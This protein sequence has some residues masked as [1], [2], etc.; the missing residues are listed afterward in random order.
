D[1]GPGELERI[2][3]VIDL[4]RHRGELLAAAAGGADELYD[5]DG[6]IFER[7]GAVERT[8]GEAAHHD[9]RL[10]AEAGK[11]AEAAA[12]VEDVARRLS[13]YGG[14]A[15][16]DPD[17]L[18]ELDD[19]REALRRLTRKHRADLDGVIA[20][21]AAL[22]AERE[23][24][25]RFEE[26]IATAAA[27]LDTRRR[28]A[29]T[30][31]QDLRRARVETASKLA[32]AVTRELHD[33]SFSGAG[34]EVRI[35]QTGGEPGAAGGDRVEFHAA[36]NPGEGCHPLRKAA[37][38][39]ELSR[40]MLAIRRVLAGVG[41]VGS[42]VFD[43]VDAGI[44]GAVAA[45]VGLKLREVAAHH[46]VICVTHLPQ[47]SALADAHFVVTKAARRG[48]TVT[49]VARLDPEQRV[50]EVAR[51]LGGSRVTPAIRDAARELLATPAR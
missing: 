16:A 10:A 20:L 43:E 12:L 7:L 47:I 17:R 6:S 22:A 31:A 41:P 38:G 29:A 28:E 8:L 45:A 24:L 48:R 26:A 42:Y 33:L 39:G 34:F 9:P 27:D 44:G 25:A 11:L 49:R 14:G 19:R 23:T 2:E 15:E 32:R 46:Q 5:R 21:R 50:E 35:E 40:L 1:P 4:L 37:S 30:V 13:G 36:L 51:M 3:G 18:E